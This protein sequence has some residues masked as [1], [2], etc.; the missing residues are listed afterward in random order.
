MNYSKRTGKLRYKPITIGWLMKRTVVI[1]Q[2]EVEY[3]HT[4]CSGGMV[5]GEFRKTWVDARPEWL[6]QSPQEQSDE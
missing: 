2:A 5:D 3:F 6:M 1:V 4:E